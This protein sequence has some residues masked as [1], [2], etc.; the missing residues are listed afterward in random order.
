MKGLDLKNWGLW[1]WTEAAC[2]LVGAVAL[3]VLTWQKESPELPRFLAGT[4]WGYVPLLLLVAAVGI[5]VVR[6]NFW[7]AGT[8]AKANETPPMSAGWPQSEPPSEFKLLPIRYKV[9]FAQ[10]LPDVEV[11]IYAIHFLSQPLTLAKVTLTLRLFGHALE[12]ITFRDEDLEVYPKEARV[13]FCRRHLTD[14]ERTGLPWRAGRETGSFDL[15]AKATRGGQTYSYKT[16]AHVIEGWVNM[17][18]RRTA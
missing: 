11:S 12:D 18:P 14:A 2:L 3:A 8:A 6:I 13:V 15:S 7:G 1:E 17:P 4:H 5:H 10:T 9:D 16:N